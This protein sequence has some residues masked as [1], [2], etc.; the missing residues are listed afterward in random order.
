[1]FFLFQLI[2]GYAYGRI[3][4]E[5]LG[6]RNVRRMFERVDFTGNGADCQVPKN[7]IQ[8]F[9]HDLMIYLKEK[10]EETKE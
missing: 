2:Q 7:Q 4:R 6:G 8:S 10:K 3:G 9:A 1:M 5:F